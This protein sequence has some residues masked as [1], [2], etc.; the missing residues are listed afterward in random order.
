MKAN[1]WESRDRKSKNS[2]KMVMVGK[3]TRL[4]ARIIAEKAKENGKNNK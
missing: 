3:S 2:K 4:I 1:K